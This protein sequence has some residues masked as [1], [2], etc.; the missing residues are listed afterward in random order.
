MNGVQMIADP[1]WVYALPGDDVLSEVERQLG[2]ESRLGSDEQWTE[3]CSGA[4]KLLLEELEDG[5]ALCALF[6]VG[7]A[8]GEIAIAR[9]SLR[10]ANDLIADLGLLYEEALIEHRDDR[11]QATVR[12]LE[13]RLGTAV[14]LQHM[15]QEGDEQPV[16]YH[17]YL[18]PGAEGG[19]AV[20]CFSSPAGWAGLWGP[21][22]EAMVLS[23]RTDEEVQ[24]DRVTL[25]TY[26][27]AEGHQ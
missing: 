16:D 6:I 9:A 8:D 18:I 12:L 19:I 26:V 3:L 23:L 24:A 15:L 11:F 17:G 7:Q 2:R 4:A 1:R 20:D 10:F 27:F 21:S 22:L 13:T 5:V 25:L 14:H